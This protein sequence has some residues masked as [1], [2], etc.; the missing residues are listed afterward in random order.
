MLSWLR[1]KLVGVKVTAIESLFGGIPINKFSTYESYLKAGTKKIWA[2]WKACDIVGTSVA[3]TPFV[4]TRGQSTAPVKNTELTQL[5]TYPNRFETFRELTYKTIMHLKLT[6]N[7]YWYKSEA[8]M[9][10]DRP[11]EIFALNPKR[12]SIVPDK[13]GEIIGYIYKT[14]GKEIPY[15]PDEIIHFKR[16][17]PDNDFY[18]IGDIEAGEAI[19]DEHINRNLWSEGFWKNGASPSGLLICEE[20]VTDQ[21]AWNS[22]KAKWQKEYGGAKN[23]GKTAWLTGKWRYE[24]LG[25]TAQE[26]QNIELSKMNVESIFMMHGVPLSVA[27]IREAANYATADIDNQRFKEYTVMPMVILIQDSMNTDLITGWGENLKIQFNVSGLI[28]A[29]KVILDYVPLFDRGG[30]SINEMREKAG[31][32]RDD[33]NDL[34]NQHFINAGLVPLD[35]SGIA[36]FGTTDQAA[37]RTVSR[38]IDSAFLTRNETNGK[39]ETDKVPAG[40]RSP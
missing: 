7:A 1:K 40:E 2:T 9:K 25:L 13:N 6:G 27:G 39:N 38:F 20:N 15:D 12:M 29:G 33:E 18:G 16:P 34:W 3:S 10:G 32:P 36:D 19:F 37:Q 26:M 28:N 35:L 14:Q 21:D 11:K 31:L 5:L 24:Q 17:H 30:M 22:A 4:V 8:T 23:A